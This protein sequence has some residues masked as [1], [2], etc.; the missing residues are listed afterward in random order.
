MLIMSSTSVSRLVSKVNAMLSNSDIISAASDRTKA[1]FTNTKMREKI[2]F[3]FLFFDRQI[4]KL[5]EYCELL[6]REQSFIEVSMSF[7]RTF[8]GS[9]LVTC[10]KKNYFV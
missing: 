10:F 2:N 8:L 3:I 6:M 4:R 5:K 1:T 9:F 7:S